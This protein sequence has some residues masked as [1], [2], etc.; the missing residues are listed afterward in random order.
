MRVQNLG[1]QPLYVS[2]FDIGLS[3]RVRLLSA[4]ERADLERR[5]AEL[6]QAAGHTPTVLRVDLG[7]TIAEARGRAQSDW[8]SRDLPD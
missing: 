5:L 7:Q 3:L 2:I 6:D 4:A 8:A 1:V